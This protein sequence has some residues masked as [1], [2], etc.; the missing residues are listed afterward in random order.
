MTESPMPSEY[1]RPAEFI[2]HPTDFSDDSNFAL[3]HALRLALSNQAEVNMLH[4]GKDTDDEWESFPS[5]RYILQRWGILKNGADRSEVLDLGIDI[6]KVVS[7]DQSLVESIEGYCHH[8][9]I[10]LIVMATAGRNAFRAALPIIKSRLATASGSIL[11]E[12]FRAPI[13]EPLK[14]E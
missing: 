14:L 4:V 2:L 13:L 11:G 10:D 8:R 12:F 3:A 9:P 7:V 1:S 5:V 6:E